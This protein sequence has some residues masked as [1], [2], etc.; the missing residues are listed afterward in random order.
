MN[1]ANHSSNRLYI[2]RNLLMLLALFT[3]KLLLNILIRRLWDTPY[4]FF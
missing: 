2:L 4:Y 1:K 3:L